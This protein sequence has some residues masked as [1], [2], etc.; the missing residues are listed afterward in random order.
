MAKILIVDDSRMSRKMLRTI[1]EGSGHEI[2]GEAVNGQ[3]GVKLYQELKPDVVTLDITMPEM[4]GISCLKAIK[5][6]DAKAKVVMITAA[7]QS[8]KLMEA[9]KAGAKEF[10]C[11]PY[12]AEQVVNAIDEVL[13]EA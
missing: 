7:G 5:E 1:L 13:K 2:A 8:S 9:L 6:Q 12:E 4:D 10:I 11:K 3:E